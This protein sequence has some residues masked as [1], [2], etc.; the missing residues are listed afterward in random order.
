MLLEKVDPSRSDLYRLPV[1]IL[2]VSTPIGQ[3]SEGSDPFL[4]T[5]FDMRPP[6]RSGHQGYV[7]FLSPELE[8]NGLKQLWL[9]VQQTSGKGTSAGNLNVFKPKLK[10]VLFA[11]IKLLFHLFTA[12]LQHF[13][14]FSL[15]TLHSAL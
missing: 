7:N 4:N 3:S 5:Y 12:A 14:V 11:L 1:S 2:S 6:K 8:R 9:S 15:L 13:N 10:T